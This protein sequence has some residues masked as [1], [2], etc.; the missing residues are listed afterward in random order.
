MALPRRGRPTL[1][2]VTRGGVADGAVLRE[3]IVAGRPDTD[4]PLRIEGVRVNGTLDLSRCRLAGPIAFVD[5]VFEEP[6]RLEELEVAGLDLTGS[7]LPALYADRLVVNGELRLSDARLGNGS[8]EPH[9]LRDP[10]VHAPRRVRENSA[11][12]VVRLADA[13]VS[14]NLVAENLR[15]A[16]TGHWSLLAPRLSIGGSLHAR[17][18]FASSALYLRDAHVTYTVMLEGADIGGLDATGLVSGGGLYADWG[19]S[20]TGQVLL[21]A[22]EIGGVV[23]FH[24]SVLAEPA[25]ALVLSRLRVPRLRVDLR[26]PPAGAVVLTDAAVDVLVDSATTWPEPGHLRL[27]GLTYQRLET[28]LPVDVRSRIGWLT[29]DPQAGAGAFEQLAKAYEAAGDERSARTVRHARERHI[30]RNDGFTGRVWGAVQDVLFGYGYAPRR[31][32]LWL[33][34]L[35]AAGSL[36]FAGHPPRPAGGSAQRAWDPVLYS[37]DLLVPI[38]SLGYRGSWDPAGADKAV[39][40]FLIV[41]GWTLATAVI[42]GARR[43]LGRA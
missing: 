43:V 14:G 40:V 10:V 42:A 3:V 37:L 15:L 27:E 16:G 21:R 2:A 9:P 17:R 32:L 26:E 39:A 30:R 20:S 34:G 6:V 35:V 28:R 31:A 23:T 7:T 41:A 25:G 8:E 38:A 29:R 12:A 13:R 11:T 1:R 36:W 18:L 33:I 5:C 22:A 19:F 4:A 24:D